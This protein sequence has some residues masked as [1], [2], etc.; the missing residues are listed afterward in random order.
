MLLRG[1]QYMIISVGGWGRDKCSLLWHHDSA[2]QQGPTW[3]TKSLE[4][5][6]KARCRA[7]RLP[8]SM[9]VSGHKARALD[10][11]VWDLGSAAAGKVPK[12]LDRKPSTP[13]PYKP[14]MKP[15]WPFHLPAPL[16]PAARVPSR[17]SAFLA[18]GSGFG[19]GGLGAKRLAV[20][21]KDG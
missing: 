19:F 15:G 5:P 13:K 12:P 3:A 16:Q 9:A 7:M 14:N 2:C 1:L 6:Q 21:G 17:I 10:E 18:L 8:G 11:I 4:T 20:Q